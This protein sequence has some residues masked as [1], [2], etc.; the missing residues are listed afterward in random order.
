MYCGDLSVL[1]Q[2]SRRLQRGIV[3]QRLKL[4]A[5]RKYSDPRTH[6]NVRRPHRADRTASLKDIKTRNGPRCQAMISPM[7]PMSSARQHVEEKTVG[8][9]LDSTQIDRKYS[10]KPIESISPSTFNTD[11]GLI[12]WLDSTSEPEVPHYIACG[13]SRGR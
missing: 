6:S 8:T 4:V 7:H 13:T 12:R 10:P 11:I 5:N 9:R 3:H 2:T 1:T